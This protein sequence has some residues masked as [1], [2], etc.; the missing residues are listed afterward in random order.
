VRDG[1]ARGKEAREPPTTRQGPHGESDGA[2][3][4]ADRNAVHTGSIPMAQAPRLWKDGV[5]REAANQVPRERVSCP[6]ALVSGRLGQ[7]AQT[8]VKSCGYRRNGNR[9]FLVAPG[10]WTTGVEPCAVKAARTVL[11]GGLRHEVVS[12]IVVLDMMS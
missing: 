6:R 4:S 12:V 7:W 1:K 2:E 8:R 9:C 5:Q 3:E 10:R 11:N